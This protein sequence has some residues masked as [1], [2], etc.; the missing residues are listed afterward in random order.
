MTRRKKVPVSDRVEPCPPEKIGHGGNGWQV[1]P[2]FRGALANQGER[3]SRRI[4]VVDA[5][6]ADIPPSEHANGKEGIDP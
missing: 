6:D 3:I 2:E 4:E 1:K 5:S